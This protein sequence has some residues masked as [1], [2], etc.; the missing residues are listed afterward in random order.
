MLSQGFGFI[1]FV[2]REQAMK[3]WKKMNGSL[4][5]G[6]QLQL[7]FSRKRIESDPSAKRKK[8]NVGTSSCKINVKNI[9]FQASKKELREL[10]QYVNS[11]KLHN[12]F[13]YY[14]LK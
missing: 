9:A 4:L 1:E 2:S 3:A 8:V 13:T 12:Y 6:H 10:F 5:D 7:S 14:L 11:H